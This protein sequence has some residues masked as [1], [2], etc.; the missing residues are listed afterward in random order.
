M[1]LF[2]SLFG[3][4]TQSSTPA[5]SPAPSSGQQLQGQNQPQNQ[6]GQSSIVPGTTSPGKEVSPLEQYKDVWTVDPEANKPTPGMFEGLDPQAILKSAQ[7]VDFSK[8][9]SP[10]L[11]TKIQN[12]G[13][14]AV[15]ALTVAMNAMSQSVYAQSAVA[16][17]K[18]VEQA[19]AKQAEQFQAQL[20]SLVK[21]LSANESLS[22]ANP[23]F[24]NPALEPVV[25]GLSEQ[26]LR[27]NPNATSSDI[28]RQVQD[29]FNAVGLSFAPKSEPTP[30]QKKAT[31]Q[32]EDWSK[33]FE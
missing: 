31:K 32:E 28:Q 7:K 5:Q 8:A 16:T 26:F 24:N 21:K 11:M 27:K 3:S 2:Q 33:F 14:D 1:N 4:Q 17:T 19:L 18:I 29:Y 30:A 9:I 15:S 10:E 23:L 6:E 22:T 12:G 25:R 20:P 13:Q